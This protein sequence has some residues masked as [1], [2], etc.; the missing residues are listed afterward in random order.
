V[1]RE[2]ELK[3]WEILLFVEGEHMQPYHKL[4]GDHTDNHLPG[5]CGV[6]RAVALNDW[7][8]MLLIF[9]TELYC[10]WLYTTVQKQAFLCD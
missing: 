9:C 8:V 4:H 3:I 1:I 2:A 5:C 6:I 10:A 7:L